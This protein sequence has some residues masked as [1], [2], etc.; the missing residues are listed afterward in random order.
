MK[1]V[2]LLRGINVGG[3]NIIKMVE[4]KECFERNGF[5]KV[6][7]YIQSGNVIF[8]SAEKNKRKLTNKLE[9][10][11]SN[12]FTYKARVILKSDEQIKEIIKNVPEE[13]NKQQ[14]IRCYIG[15]L[16]EIIYADEATKEIK[17]NEKVDSLKSGP[18]AVYMTTLMSGRTKSAFN[19]L[20]GTKIYQEMTIRNFNTT[21]KI[22]ELL[23]KL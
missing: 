13:W 4:L 1:Y 19:K 15:F 9:E 17:V 7:T 20:I 3:K 2:A 6:V 11:L 23:E 21:K 8:E 22:L 12:T 14:D 10:M 18:G 16:S 5:L